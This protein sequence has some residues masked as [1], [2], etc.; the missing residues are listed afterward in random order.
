MKA[1][2]WALAVGA[3]ADTTLSAFCEGTLTMFTTVLPMMR[4]PTEACKSGAKWAGDCGSK[5]VESIFRNG[6]K[7][8]DANPSFA[9]NTRKLSNC[10]ARSFKMLRHWAKRRPCSALLAT[11]RGYCGCSAACKACSTLRPSAT[12]YT[13]VVPRSSPRICAN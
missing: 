2:R 7:A 5:G 10:G 12:K 9:A 6:A 13:C 1:Q 11:K 4:F 3:K 8:S